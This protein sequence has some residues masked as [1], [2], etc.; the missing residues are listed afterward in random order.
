MGLPDMTNLASLLCP[1]AALQSY[2]CQS[3]TEVTQTSCNAP[4]SCQGCS[5]F[6]SV[7]TRQHHNSLASVDGQDS[8]V[9][10]FL[11]MLPA[12]P[13]SRHFATSKPAAFCT[14]VG[15]YK[16][17]QRQQLQ[18]FDNAHLHLISGHLTVS[19]SNWRLSIGSSWRASISKALIWTLRIASSGL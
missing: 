17:Q 16:P 4:P 3:T 19:A 7:F 1:T 8:L 5:P 9:F 13:C 12:N 15:L 6:R 2:A 14:T 11:F 10:S 18:F